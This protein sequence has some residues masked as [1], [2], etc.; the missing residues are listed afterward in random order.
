MYKRNKDIH[1]FIGFHRLAINGL[2]IKSDQPMTIETSLGRLYFVCNG[3]IY[4]YKQLA[5]EFNIELTSGSDCEIIP[6]LFLKI[7]IR[8]T[9]QRLDGV[10]AF[11]LSYNDR[12]YIGRDPIGVRPLFILW[13]IH[14]VVLSSVASGCMGFNIQGS[15]KQVPPGTLTEMN[16]S[17][18]DATS[19]LYYWWE[20]PKVVERLVPLKSQ[21]LSAVIRKQLIRAT[22]KRLM[23]ERPIGC[24]LSGG[25]DSSVI[26]SILSRQVTNLQT[27][28]IGFSTDSTDLKAAR[29]VAQYL[30]TVHNEV[31]IPYSKALEAIPR[32][33]Q[34]LETFDITTIRASVG[35]FLLSEWIKENSDVVV[36]YS[37]EGSDE[38]FCGYL[39]FHGAPNFVSLEKESR[40]LL[41][42]L[43]LYDVLRADRTTASHGLELRVPFLDKCLIELIVKL[44]GEYRHPHQPNEER[45]QMEK[46]LL[47][48]AFAK[49]LPESIVWRRKEGFSDG[50]SSLEKSWYTVIQE[51]VESLISDAELETAKGQESNFAPITKESVWYIK[52]FDEKFPNFRNSLKKYWMPQWTD[53]NDP[54]GRVTNAFD[55]K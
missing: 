45:T 41:N 48:K 40:R 1:T 5:V 9:I 17:G 39:Y 34:S 33:I 8:E 47:R 6:R 4:N 43:H 36:L 31:I 10:F 29:K 13:G 26:A 12:I 27:F 11:I 18:K 52:I 20:P 44:P 53:T 2:D 3:E 50:V 23:S 30:G 38:L 42:E 15:V 55:E 28:S 32:V 54:S 35:M 22:R 51:H 46:L 21:N 37:G 19:Q 7:G 24:L 16:I 25:L 49:D 14:S